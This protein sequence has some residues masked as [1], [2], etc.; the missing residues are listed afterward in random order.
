MHLRLCEGHC[1]LIRFTLNGTKHRPQLT[2]KNPMIL[3][4]KH[5]RR[6]FLLHTIYCDTQSSKKI[7]NTPNVMQ[8]HR[9][10]DSVCSHMSCCDQCYHHQTH[11]VT[12][13]NLTVHHIER[14]DVAIII[15][16]LTDSFTHA[17]ISVLVPTFLAIC[18][19]AFFSDFDFFSYKKF[20]SI[21]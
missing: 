6:L 9:E 15:K 21:Q 16:T 19:Q 14:Y 5:I 4:D 11:Y 12:S 13:R 7:E 8:T 3:H 17:R 20:N 10:R 18:L 1:V 2:M